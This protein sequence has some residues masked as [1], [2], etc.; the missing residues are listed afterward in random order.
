MAFPAATG[1]TTAYFSSASGV[2]STTFA[3]GPAVQSA[4]YAIYQDIATG[5]MYFWN[6]L[7][8]AWVAFGGGGGGTGAETFISEVAVTG[9]VAAS[10]S[11]SSIA[12]TYRHLRLRCKVRDNSALPADALQ[13]NI[14]SDSTSGHYSWGGPINTNG[15]VTGLNTVGGTFMNV[16][17]V[18]GGT[19]NAANF[20][21]AEITLPYYA[22]TDNYKHVQGV[23]S[24]HD[25]G[26]GYIING[27]RSGI[28]FASSAITALSFTPGTGSFSI[29]SKISLYGVS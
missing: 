9:A 6:R 14:N 24:R 18:A 7:T 21:V 12:G 13:L 20:A 8:A 16:G 23:Y 22:D 10:I 19:Q 3:S 5:L 11:F 28:W 25:T 17:D 29:G 26:A 27:V 1:L 4:E 15:T 2:P